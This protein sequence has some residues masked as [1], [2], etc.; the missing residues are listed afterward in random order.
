MF[1]RP[2]VEVVDVVL[3]HCL[4][5]DFGKLE[6]SS[7]SERGRDAEGALRRPT[8]RVPR[9]APR[10]LPVSESGG[11]EAMYSLRVEDGRE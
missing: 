11:G 9:K 4:E 2:E 1:P 7:V 8:P 5:M 6:G 3:V 10:L